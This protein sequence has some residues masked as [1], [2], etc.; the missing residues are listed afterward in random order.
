[1]PHKTKMRS[2]MR[3]IVGDIGVVEFT[4]HFSVKCQ[5]VL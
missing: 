1:M 2:E 4:G 5:W 3:E